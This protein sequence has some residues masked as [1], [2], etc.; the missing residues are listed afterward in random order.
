[1]VPTNEGF[2]L[3]PTSFAGRGR[4][5]TARYQRASAAVLTA[6]LPAGPDAT[7]ASAPH[8]QAGRGNA[9]ALPSTGPERRCYAPA[10][11]AARRAFLP[12]VREVPRHALQTLRYL[13]PGT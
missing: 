3:K 4:D 11:A 13:P 9:R 5:R 12:A 2:D 10:I 8:S 1:M 7:A 6:S